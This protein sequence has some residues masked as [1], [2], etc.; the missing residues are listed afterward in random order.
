MKS[1][2]AQSNKAPPTPKPDSQYVGST[3]CK[4][5]H[6][7][8]WLNFYK[9][10]HFK[11]MTSGKLPLSELSGLPRLQKASQ[12]TRARRVFASVD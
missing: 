12:N 4:A 11:S 2:S 6:P 5:C 1:Q 9:N 3:V 7:N 8:V 10:P